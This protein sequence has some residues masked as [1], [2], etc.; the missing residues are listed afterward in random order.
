[1]KHTKGEWTVKPCDHVGAIE[2]SFGDFKGEVKLWYHHGDTQTKEEA[3][4]NARLI[5]SAP[6]LLEELTQ[7]V[8]ALKAINSMGATT[9]IIERAEKVIEKAT[10]A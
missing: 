3:E 7:C 6:K 9:P 1:M 10:K 5:A 4:A 2:V 8:K